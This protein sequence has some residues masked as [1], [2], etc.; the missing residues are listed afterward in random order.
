LP[1]DLDP[2][3]F[4]R[5]RAAAYIT[6]M[7]PIIG[8]EGSGDHLFK[9]CRAFLRDFA[10]PWED[11]WALLWKWN[12]TCEPSWSP[13]SLKTVLAAARKNGKRSVGR[14]LSVTG[15]RRDEEVRQRLGR[16]AG[17]MRFGDP[18]GEAANLLADLDACLPWMS[19]MK[20]APRKDRLAAL[21]LAVDRYTDTTD[22][23]VEADP[24][25]WLLDEV[26]SIHDALTTTSAPVKEWTDAKLDWLMSPDVWNGTGRAWQP[27]RD[28]GEEGRVSGSKTYRTF[29]DAS[30]ATPVD[31]ETAYG[32]QEVLAIFRDTLS[33][34]E[35]VVFDVSASTPAE[36]VARH[37]NARAGT[38]TAT[39][40][41][42]KTCRARILK[43]ARAFGERMASG[44][45][46]VAPVIR[47]RGA[48][49]TRLPAPQPAS[50]LACPP[51]PGYAGQGE[52]R[53]A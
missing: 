41:S 36:V 24:A 27:P 46:P 8:S 10:L 28:A 22:P 20:K 44:L 50:S 33:P 18:A 26:K 11:A 14:L 29:P 3:H 31:P 19:D 51:A 39:A 9:V 35:R 16:L 7:G 2:L 4:R 42:V 34:Q 32:R 21:Y 17:S 47:A 13:R 12:A 23:I 43:K 30:A 49:V 40:K 5:K 37:L 25:G 6:K 1:T 53:A 45:D 38:T 15:E 52:R 48:T